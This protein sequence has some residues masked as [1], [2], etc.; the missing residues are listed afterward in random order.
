[1][2]ILCE[3]EGVRLDA[4][5]AARDLGLSRSALQ[6]LLED[7]AVRVDGRPVK[8]NYKTRLGDGHPL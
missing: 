8:K 4:F 6:K 2:T 1:M 3:T 7:G 5:L